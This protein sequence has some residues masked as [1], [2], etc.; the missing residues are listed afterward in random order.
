M[1]SL[2]ECIVVCRH[3]SRSSRAFLVCVSP[4]GK[5]LIASA[6]HQQRAELEAERE[7]DVAAGHCAQSPL[8]DHVSVDDRTLSCGHDDDDGRV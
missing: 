8:S 7:A 6:R 5:E 3:E 4:C 1:W 2:F